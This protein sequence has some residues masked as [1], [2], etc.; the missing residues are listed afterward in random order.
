VIPRDGGAAFPGFEYVPGHGPNIPV[1]LPNGG[2][3]WAAYAT[4]MRLRDYFAAHAPLE[5]P[6]W[7]RHVEPKKNFPP[8]ADVEDL[9]ETHRKL[10]RDWRHDPCFDLPEE[11][12][13]WGEKVKAHRAARSEWF[14]A[15]VRARFIQWRWAYADAMLAARVVS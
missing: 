5:V 6:E 3:E 2:K 1:D 7:F 12:A 4:G 8:D 11:I 14:E 10:A 9:D 13:W 15:D